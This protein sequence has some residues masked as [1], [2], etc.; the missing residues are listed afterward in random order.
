MLASSLLW[1]ISTVVSQISMETSV[2][3]FNID[4]STAAYIFLFSALGAII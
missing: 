2:E 1:S 4:A 3:K